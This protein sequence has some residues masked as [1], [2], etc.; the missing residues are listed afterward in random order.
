MRGDDRP[1][2][3]ARCAKHMA[4][5]GEHWSGERQSKRPIVGLSRW[6]DLDKGAVW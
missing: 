6:I 2:M 3:K 4:D 1:G 5:K